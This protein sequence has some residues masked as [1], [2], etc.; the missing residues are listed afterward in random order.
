MVPRC[1]FYGE[2]PLIIILHKIIVM[3]YITVSKL[4]TNKLQHVRHVTT[5]CFFF[6]KP[7]SNSCPTF[8]QLMELLSQADFE[9]FGWEE[10]DLRNNDPVQVKTI[11]AP[12]ETAKNLYPDLQTL[13]YATQD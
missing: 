13:Y 3:C 6:R 1:S 2:A 10:E 8:P 7:E 12:L 4:C 5:K 11:G 9:L